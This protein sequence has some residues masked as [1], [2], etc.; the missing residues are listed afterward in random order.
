MSTSQ[1]DPQARLRR[2]VYLLLIMA[3]TGIMLGRIL[4]IDAIGRT[5]IEDYRF[6]RILGEKAKR[7]RQKGLE[8]D[9]Y[10]EA[11]ERERQRLLKLLPPLRR[12]FFSANDRSR[13]CAVRALVEPDMRVYETDAQGNTRWVPYAIDNV[14]QQPNWDTIDM[15][16]HDGHLYSSKPPLLPTLIAG[17]YWLIYNLTGMS[18]AT[19]P[20][21]LGRFM[22][23]SINL[24]PLLVYFVLLSR[25][26]D[27][28]GA[29]DWGR[30]LVMTAAVFGT[31]LTTFAV[32][33]NNHVPTAIC[34][35]IALVAAVPIWFD[36]RRH[37]AY[38]AM[39]GLFAAL[40]ATGELP[41][42]AFAAALSVVL[43]WKAPR[44][45]LLV[46]VPVAVLVAAA[47]FGT[48]WIAHQDLKPP[49]MHRGQTDKSDNW[50]DYT[51]EVNGKQYESYWNNPGGLDQGEPSWAIYAMHVLVGHHGIFSLTPVW[52]L[53]AAGVIMWLC[54]GRD[55]RLRELA[56][57]IGVVTLAC[58]VF[59]LLRPLHHRNYG[60]VTS[61]LRW[62]FWLAPLW[63]LTMLPAAD[64]M[65][66]RR[67]T[68]AIVLLLL[69]AS[70]LSAS[71]PTWNPWVNPWI[72]D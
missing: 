43:L 37:W 31:F 24:L 20:F 3:G 30:C 11:L 26:V 61:G 41:A 36:N 9:R 71:Y 70:V 1:D 27:R 32:T 8:G 25:L 54:R 21:A 33:L 65:S 14:I 23:L 6:D 16:K 38:F 34:V 68:R 35:L 7:L 42:L 60:G 2:S 18:L 28:F 10:D 67:W 58:L 39:A 64:A 69:V 66:G 46:Y 40:A 22:L 50:Y 17:E 53:S 56:L 55:P 63:L 49:Y 52:L 4:A 29:T 62:M 47:F 12:P 15:V 45:T 72:M 44:R 57:L 19:H 48:N 13:W 51:Y 59:Y 5:A